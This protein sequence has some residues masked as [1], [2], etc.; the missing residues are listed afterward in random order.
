M[1]WMAGSRQHILEL[2]ITRP[3]VLAPIY[4]LGFSKEVID[5]YIVIVGF[6]AMFNHAYVSVR[7]GALRYV[8]GDDVP[9]GFIQ[10]LKLSLTWT[11]R[12]PEAL[13]APH[14]AGECPAAQRQRARAT[15]PR[16]GR[17]PGGK[18]ASATQGGYSQLRDNHPFCS[19]DC[20]VLF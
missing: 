8:L 17:L 2:L 5:T 7:L 18:G 15:P 11:G 13:R 3:L 20:C 14:K 9:N 12:P 6:Q 1:N 19:L 10:Q 4:V 16:S